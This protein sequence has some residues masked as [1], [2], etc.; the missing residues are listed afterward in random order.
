MIDRLFTNRVNPRAERSGE[1]LVMAVLN[2]TPDSFF[3]GSREMQLSKIIDV[4]GQMLEDGA[5]IIDVGGM[6][7]RPGST[8]PSI[9]EEIDRISSPLL[10]LRAAYPEAVLSIDTYRSPVLK[11]CIDA[12]IDIVNDI[13]AGTMDEEFLDLVAAYDLPYVLMHMQGA[14]R[15]MQADPYYDDV[16]LD[17]MKFLDQ[18]IAV[19][20]EKGIH[21]IIIDP[22]FGFGK[23]VAH[24]YQLLNHLASLQIFDLP[25]LAGM[26]RK[27]MIYKPLGVQPEDALNGTTALNM[28]ALDR[29]AEVI[30]VHDVKEAKE[31]I[32]LWQLLHQNQIR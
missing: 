30:R 32:R 14:P 22:G 25:V 1:P 6:S 18:K 27:S 12:K 9:S 4:V 26:S 21:K 7:S 13:S 5:D 24:N 29:G 11:L 17:V 8:A 10:A 20:H 16:V 28:M 19:L 3:G 15:S 31:C 23:T 2:I